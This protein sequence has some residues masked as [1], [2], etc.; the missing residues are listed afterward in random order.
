MM[1]G[2]L[3]NV[4][5]QGLVNLNLEDIMSAAGYTCCRYH[6]VMTFSLC[7]TML[8]TKTKTKKQTHTDCNTKNEPNFPYV[9]YNLLCID[10]V[11][12][13]LI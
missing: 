1:L 9:I 2:P 3:I 4:S 6:I 7:I 12:L 10:S 11:F 8:I 5:S 13:I